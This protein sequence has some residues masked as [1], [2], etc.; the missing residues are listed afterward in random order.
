VAARIFGTDTTLALADLPDGGAGTCWFGTGPVDP[1]DAASLARVDRTPANRLRGTTRTLPLV[2]MQ[3]D[4][5]LG[6]PGLSG[7]RPDGTDWSPRFTGARVEG[8][9]VV[10]S[11]AG[12]EL[13]TEIEALPGGAL[14]VRHVL[15]N[16]GSDPYLVEE[17]DVIVPVPDRVAERL[18]TTGRWALE[19]AVQRGPIDAGVWLR[20][21]RGGR[22]GHDSPTLLVAGTAGFGFRSGEVW[23]AHLGWSGNT[24]HFLERR[25]DGQTVLG[26]GEL[27]L[28]GELTLA[29]G[30]SYSTPWVYLVGS[31][32]G[33][34]GL[35]RQLHA[36]QRSLPAHPRD[37]QPVVCNVWEAVYFDHDL[38]RLTELARRAAAVG[39]ERY[40]LDDGWFGS[41]REE[42]RGLGDWTVS[43]EVWPDGLAPLADRVHDLGM[44]FGLWFEPEMVNPDSELYRAHP[45]WI[46]ATGGR[47]PPEWRHQQVLDLSRRE[48]RDHLVRQID[49]VLASAAID[50]VKWDHNRE[51]IEA[52]SSARGGAAAVHDQTLGYL[53]VLDRLRELHPD[54]EWESCASGGARIDL[55]VIEHVQRFWTSDLT[56]ALGRQHIQRWTQLLIAPEYLGAHVSAPVNH[57]TGRTFSLDF[58]AATAFFGAMGIEW[59]LTSAPD[60]DLARLRGWIELH[61]RHRALLHGGETVRVDVADP[62]ILLHGV[63]APDRLSAVFGYVQL[64][65]RVATPPPFLLPGLDPGRR[66]RVR[67]LHPDDDTALGE[68]DGRSLALLGLRGPRRQELH[69]DLVDVAAIPGR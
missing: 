68:Y 28:P 41:R 60:D 18:D 29:P 53:D 46:L 49:T 24:R 19:R 64:G 12:L 35:T 51:L 62:E 16:V 36:F 57:Q 54:V 11:D 44:Q 69:I 43:P 55:G 40:V 15:T 25:P 8:G 39:A 4:G 33:L 23:G 56:D 63:V 21:T 22:S 61:K 5:W 67:R 13:A 17:L 31:D 52:G 9:R 45:D 7:S 20:E 66:Y 30:A 48:V 6:R 65:A 1:D 3:G 34:D 50:Y 42:T 37:P 47:I 58:R 14:R 10:A 38:D 27:L 2:P 59:D 32:Q 26:A